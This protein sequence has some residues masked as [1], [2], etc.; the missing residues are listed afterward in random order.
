MRAQFILSEI[1]IGLR[2]NLSMTVSVVLV[3]FVCLT[4]L[5]AAAL[6]QT[7][8]GKMKDDFYDKVEVSVFLCPENSAAPTCAAG[9]V[10]QEQR[11][12]ILAALDAP[13][14]ARYVEQ[15]FTESKEEAYETFKRQW[16][17]QF[18]ASAATA[19]DMNSSLRIKLT[20]PEQYQVVADVVSGRPGVESVQDQRRLFDNLFLV[21]DRATWAAGGLAAIMLLAAV[22]LITTTIR[23]SALSRRRETGIMRLVGAST[24]FIQ[25]PFMLEGAIAAT[26]GA[27]LAIGGLWLGVEYLVTDW[28]GKSVTWIPYVGTSDV[29]TIA[30]LLVLVAFVLAAISSLVTL[31]RYTKV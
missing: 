27:G 16:G 6:L 12:D 25:L 18:W 28:L 26:L 31:S 11:D 22:L 2:R 1:G 23:L 9:E 3:T 21:L 10:T 8:I 30:P 20:D 5:G 4:F 15:I 29:L 19:D 17:D 24:L 13:D 7:Q 14:V